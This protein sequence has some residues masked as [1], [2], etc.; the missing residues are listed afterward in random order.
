MARADTL[1]I[2][3]I[4]E[5]CGKLCAVIQTRKDSGVITVQFEEP[6]PN[7]AYIYANKCNRTHL[8]MVKHGTA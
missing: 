3:D 2:G 6:K 7:I 8:R 4:V 1:Q 5:Y